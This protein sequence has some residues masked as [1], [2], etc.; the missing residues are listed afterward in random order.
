MNSST[1]KSPRQTRHLSFIS[2]FTTDLRYVDGNDNISSDLMSRLRPPAEVGE[3]S[4]V[5]HSFIQPE[6]IS[7]AQNKER[8]VDIYASFKHSL[9]LS[10]INIGG[11]PVLVDTSQ[12]KPRPLV[13]V[14]LQTQVLQA[15]H[16]L[17]HCQR[18]ADVE[19]D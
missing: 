6:A 10:T 14:C 1:D 7:D 17:A 9:V 3:V 16:D 11:H 18:S 8:T 19:I 12:L 4:A 15:F 5:S 13:P 2:E